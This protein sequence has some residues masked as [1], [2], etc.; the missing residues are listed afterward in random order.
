[1]GQISQA[2]A[3]VD[4]V[5]QKNLTA[6]RQIDQAA[7]DLNALSHRLAE[8]VAVAPRRLPLRTRLEPGRGDR[9][10]PPRFWR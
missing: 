4:L 10:D 3:S 7:A 6:I 2:M 8:T 1:M 5:V 9:G